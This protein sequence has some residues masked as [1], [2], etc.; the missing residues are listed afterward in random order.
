MTKALVKFGSVEGEGCKAGRAVA[1]PREGSAN[2]VTLSRVAR[3]HECGHDRPQA[4]PR[5][6]EDDVSGPLNRIALIT[7]SAFGFRFISVFIAL[8]LPHVREH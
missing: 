4:C 7:R 6:G 3:V 8:T 1:A 5:T 2:S